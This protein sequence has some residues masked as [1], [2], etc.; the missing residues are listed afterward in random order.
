VWKGLEEDEELVRWEEVFEL[1]CCSCATAVVDKSINLLYKIV[2]IIIATANTMA[3]PSTN[4]LLI[5][6]AEDYSSNFYAWIIRI[7]AA[8]MQ[9][10]HNYHH[11]YKHCFYS[12]KLYVF[13]S[14]KYFTVLRGVTFESI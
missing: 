7:Y 2:I 1:I 12:C 3:V 13:S 4:C 14:K 6:I 11:L 5:R 10:S 8:S 9:H